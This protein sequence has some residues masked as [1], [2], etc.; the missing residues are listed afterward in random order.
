MQLDLCIH[1]VGFPLLRACPVFMTSCLRAVCKCKH[2]VR[3]S[4]SASLPF[5]NA[6]VLHAC[7]PCLV[8]PLLFAVCMY[9]FSY[10]ADPVCWRGPETGGPAHSGTGLRCLAVG[11]ICLLFGRRCFSFLQARLMCRF[12]LVCG[13]RST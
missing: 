8:P 9:Q 2:E 13:R 7:S 5:D 12:A 4:A 3:V 6:H 1:R 11:G 10:F